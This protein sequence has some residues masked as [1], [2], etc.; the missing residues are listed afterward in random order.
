MAWAAAKSVCDFASACKASSV[1]P[2]LRVAKPFSQNG[3]VIEKIS[4]NGHPTGEKIVY[5][6]EYNSISVPKPMYNKF[7]SVLLYSATGRAAI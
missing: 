6:E 1:M 7:T 5:A 4:P 3:Q 2:G